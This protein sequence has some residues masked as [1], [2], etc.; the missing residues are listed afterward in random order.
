MKAIQIN[1]FL[2][3]QHKKNN[4]KHEPQSKKKAI[5][6]YAIA[7][8]HNQSGPTIFI[9]LGNTGQWLYQQTMPR[10]ECTDAHADLDL[11]KLYKGPFCVL[12]IIWQ[13]CLLQALCMV[14]FF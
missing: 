12:D 4:K 1:I 10:L 2:L 9:N 6:S 7:K 8:V 14:C 5:E 13:K 11:H 3:L